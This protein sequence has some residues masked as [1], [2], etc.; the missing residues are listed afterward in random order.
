MMSEEEELLHELDATKL[1][2]VVAID[3]ANLAVPLA[4]A[5]LE[6]GVK[7]IEITFRT[8]SAS[9]ALKALQDAKVKIHYGAG[10]VRTMA[11]AKRAIDAGAEF[12]V[13][14]GFNE[15]IIMVSREAGIPFYPGVDSTLAIEKSMNLGL[16]VLKF[17]PAGVIGGV[18]W[19][20]AMKGPYFDIKFIPTGGVSLS[21]LKEYVGLPNVIGIG[22]SFL[23]PKNLISEQKFDEITKVCK[24]A[25]AIVSSIKGE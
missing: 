10:T 2:A 23:S 24:E 5:L 20:K 21:N 4:N 8:A 22:G 18:K 1:I 17:F 12:M 15:E 14:P 3:D 9:D 7:F 25:S 19:L 6:G 13:S 11:Q 16:K